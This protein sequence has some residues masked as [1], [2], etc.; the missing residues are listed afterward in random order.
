M[1]GFT[2]KSS[3]VAQ[4][5]LTGIDAASTY[6]YVLVEAEHRDGDTRG[7]HLLD[8]KAQG[9]NLD[10][11]I[12]DAGAG[13]RAGQRAALGDILCHG[14]TFHIQQQ[15]EGLSNRLGRLA[16]GAVLEQF[17]Q[18]K[19]NLRV[20]GAGAGGGR[21]GEPPSEIASNHKIIGASPGQ[22]QAHACPL[23]EIANGIGCGRR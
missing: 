1:R 23:L 22:A 7:V 13:L 6:C 14:D 3:K 9:L 19:I 5:V 2:T 18:R 12:A 4:P 17:R 15:C 16:Q 10:Y 20:A 11:A 8:A 21:F